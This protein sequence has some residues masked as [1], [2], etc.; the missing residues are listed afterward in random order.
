M[1]DIQHK[2]TLI[3]DGTLVFRNDAG[4]EWIGEPIFDPGYEFSC[5]HC[6]TE[7]EDSV[8][9]FWKDDVRYCAHCAWDLFDQPEPISKYQ[10][11]R[12]EQERQEAERIRLREE[13]EERERQHWRDQEEE[14]EYYLAWRE[15]QKKDAVL[16]NNI[17]AKQE[18][19]KLQERERLEDDIESTRL[20]CEYTGPEEHDPNFDYDSL[21]SDDWLQTYANKLWANHVQPVTSNGVDSRSYDWD[22]KPDFDNNSSLF[23]EHCHRQEDK[24]EDNEQ[25]QDNDD[26]LPSTKEELYKYLEA[27]LEPVSIVPEDAIKLDED[28]IYCDTYDQA[29]EVLTQAICGQ[30]DISQLLPDDSYVVSQQHGRFWYVLRPVQNNP[31]K[32]SVCVFAKNDEVAT[33]YLIRQLEECI[34]T[35]D[36]ILN[37]EDY[38]YEKHED[39]KDQ[40]YK[41]K[42]ITQDPTY[43]NSTAC[44]R[45]CFDCHFKTEERVQM[46]L[47]EH[48]LIRREIQHL[49]R[50]YFDV[51]VDY[52]ALAEFTIF[53]AYR[54]KSRC[55]Y[56]DCGITSRIE[57]SDWDAEE[58]LQFCCRRHAEHSDD[59]GCHCQNVWPS[60]SNY[61]QDYEEETCRICNSPHKE[62]IA[63]RRSKESG[64]GV[65]PIV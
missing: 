61:N 25:T 10:I 13:R 36:Y 23:R 7:M 41:C 6:G 64:Q 57:P 44:I 26:P 9:G 21:L 42:T 28:F 59:F 4:D 56:F 43:Y 55:H 47:E 54:Y 12:Q 38:P 34:Y 30:D 48:L 27:Y 19:A 20:T 18:S 40:C 45:L 2:K 37:P 11:W 50:P 33:K 58:T 5:D 39:Q 65:N 60:W 52:A 63:S 62:N 53:D 51:L 22:P 3:T 29:R 15:E 17:L 1:T 14:H 46:P 49:R 16:L 35:I 24:D 8:S 31:T 32:F